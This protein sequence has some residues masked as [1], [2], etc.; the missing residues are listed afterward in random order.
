MCS[1]ASRRLLAQMF[2]ELLDLV[3]L[4]APEHQHSILR[5]HHDDVLRA[6]HSGE[7]AA[8]TD[9]HVVRIERD[10]LATNGV[11]AFVAF[12]EL[13]D[14]IPVAPFSQPEAGVQATGSTR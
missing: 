11:A 14:R 6:D 9:M 5:R 1:L 3:A 4:L 10:A 2:D 12:A 13:E 8:R 7:R